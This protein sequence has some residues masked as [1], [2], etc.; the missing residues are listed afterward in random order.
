MLIE[1]RGPSSAK[2]AT[3]D[4]FFVLTMKGTAHAMMQN[5]FVISISCWF[6]MEI[7][8]PSG[9]TTIWKAKAHIGFKLKVYMDYFWKTTADDFLL[10]WATI[11]FFWEA[12]LNQEQKSVSKAKK[13]KPMAI[14]E[15]R[16]PRRRE[17]TRP[18]R[19]VGNIHV[20]CFLGRNGLFKY[21]FN[22]YSLFFPS[23]SL[24]RVFYGIISGVKK[25]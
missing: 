18:L 8:K 1:W 11:G 24:L 20:C 14:R 22:T 5:Y 17:A 19:G 2:I 25:P 3:A 21:E 16:L 23:I 12:N 4:F 13:P 7:E 6:G 15:K 10:L 9:I